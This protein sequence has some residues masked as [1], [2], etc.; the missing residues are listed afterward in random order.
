MKKATLEATDENILQSIK[1]QKGTER[2]TEIMEFIK[3]LDLIEENIFISLDARWGEGKTFYVR[4]IEKTLE[5]QTLKNFETDDNKNKYEEMKPYF[6]KTVLEDIELGN[7]YLPVY[8]NAWLYDNHSDPLMSLLYVIIKKCGLWIDSKLVKDKTDKL[9]DIIKSIQVNLGIFSINGDKVI[10]AVSEKNI[11]DGIQLAE[12][13]RQRVKEIFNQVIEGQTQKLVIFIDEL[14]R[15]K[16]SYALEMLD[17][18]EKNK[19]IRREHMQNYDKVYLRE[20]PETDVSDIV[21]DA[22]SNN[23]LL[24]LWEYNGERKV[25]KCEICNKKF[26]VVGNTKTCSDK[27]SKVLVKRN[28]NKT[29]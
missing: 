17:R 11:F 20:L 26:V 15:C 9:K 2:N 12:D 10:D 4:Q 28:K 7:S 8:Y 22:E 19:Y 3:A 5:Y 27:C 6:E 14:D 1:E 23:P 18:L 13:I 24:D 21:F 29:S 25:A 16:P